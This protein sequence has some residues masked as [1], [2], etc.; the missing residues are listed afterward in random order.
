MV[1]ATT[2]CIS[3]HRGKARVCVADHITR[4]TVQ[5][6]LQVALVAAAAASRTQQQEKGHTVMPLHESLQ[7][8]RQNSSRLYM[9]P[10]CFC[11]VMACKGITLWDWHDTV[12]GR[13]TM[14]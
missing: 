6:G 7:H 9:F 12:Q 5:K 3:Q 14:Y 4:R 8:C 10:P 11:P 13:L 1:L 2:L